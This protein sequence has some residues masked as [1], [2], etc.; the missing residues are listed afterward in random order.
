MPPLFRKATQ[1]DAEGVLNL[2][3]ER[4][5]EVHPGTPSP[6]S[7]NG[8][9]L[10]NQTIDSTNSYIVVGILDDRIVAT[11]TVYLLPR[12]RLGGYFAMG[13]SIVV[14]H[15]LR[16]QGIGTMLMDHIISEC[17]KDTRIR[18]IKLGSKKDET[19]IHTFYEKLGFVY[20]EKLFQL[21]ISHDIDPDL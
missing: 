16:G 19:G 12:I 18:K 8:R 15:D 21:T 17:K 13:E 1:E 9:D 10:F 3:M 20:K 2:L 5:E 14:S 4:H 6:F 11:A 7:G